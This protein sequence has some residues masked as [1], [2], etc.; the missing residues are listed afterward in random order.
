[1]RLHDRYTLNGAKPRPFIHVQLN[2]R[3]ALAP[4]PKCSLQHMRRKMRRSVALVFQW[5][6]REALNV[7]AFEHR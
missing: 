7:Y 3:C 5:K 2:A 1:M 4:Q 6:G